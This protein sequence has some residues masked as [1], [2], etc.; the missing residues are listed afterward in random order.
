MFEL[1]KNIF[2]GYVD[3][4]YEK[5]YSHGKI[6]NVPSIRLIGRITRRNPHHSKFL[7]ILEIKKNYSLIRNY[8][9]S[10]EETLWFFLGLFDGDGSIVIR[11]S[12]VP[13][14]RITQTNYEFL[15]FLRRLLINNGVTV[16]LIKDGTSGSG[17]QKWAINIAKKSLLEVVEFIAKHSK[18]KERKMR[19]EFY[20][21]E[22]YPRYIGKDP[23][24]KEII[25]EFYRRLEEYRKSVRIYEKR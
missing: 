19:A 12:G 7:E 1:F 15:S 8:I 11:K 24:L 20:L 21:A 10:K 2:G 14:V 5:H 9:N 18:H 23:R 22:V 6:V 16:T 3:N 25:E 13:F 4:I 17:K